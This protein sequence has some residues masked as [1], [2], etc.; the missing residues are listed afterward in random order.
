MLQGV[1]YTRLLPQ[2]GTQPGHRFREVMHK[3]A[4]KNSYGRPIRDGSRYPGGRK[5]VQ[6]SGQPPALSM[7]LSMRCISLI[8]S[9]M[10]AVIFM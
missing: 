2:S 5:Q 4:E 7:A 9:A 1:K 10:A 8:V 3:K 6:A